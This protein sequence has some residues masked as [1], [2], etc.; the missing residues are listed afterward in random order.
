M[1]NW[2]DEA[3]GIFARQ[4]TGETRLVTLLFD[5]F[6]FHKPEFENDLVE[7]YA[8]N[9]VIGNSSL[10]LDIIVK[11]AEGKHVVSTHAV[12]VCVDEN[13]RRKKIQRIQP[14]V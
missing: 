6:E 8:D 4:Y 14:G 11:T 2:V 9:P 7:F 1:M 13:L 10:K 12:F 3:G 5:T